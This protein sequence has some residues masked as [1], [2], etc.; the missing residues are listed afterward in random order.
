MLARNVQRLSVVSKEAGFQLEHRD[1]YY[2]KSHFQFANESS[3]NTLSAYSD[4]VD[5][6][7]ANKVGYTIYEYESHAK[8]CYGITFVDK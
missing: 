2:G 8:K 5:A 1:Y 6:I 4:A 7:K 3:P